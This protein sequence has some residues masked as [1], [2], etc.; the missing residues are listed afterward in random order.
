MMKTRLWTTVALAMVIGGHAAAQTPI[1]PASADFAM[2]A[3]QSDQYE[4]LAAHVALTQSQNPHIRTFAQ[5][6]IDDHTRDADSVREAA[7]AAGLTPPLP[8]MTS[9]QALLLAALQSLRGA[10]FDRAY[11]N[12]QILA[13][14]QALA[15]EQSYAS[16]GTD[17][18]LRKVAET[19]VPVIQHHQQMAEQIRATVGDP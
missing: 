11:I 17:T 8:G 19:T 9:D 1:P 18:H 5:Q 12:Q 10:D 4:I 13:H 2:S 14:A 15:V 7:T 16:A 6:M 3:T